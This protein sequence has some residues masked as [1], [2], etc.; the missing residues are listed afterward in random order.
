[1]FSIFRLGTPTTDLTSI[2]TVENEKVHLLK[3]QIFSINKR[4]GGGQHGQ[5]YFLGVKSLYHY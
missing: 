4:G 3:K 5:V 2:C 1:M